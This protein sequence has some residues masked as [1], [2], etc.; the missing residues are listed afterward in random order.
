[1]ITIYTERCS[2]CGACVD[3]CPTGALYLVDGKATMDKAL[4]NT[5]KECLAA[6]SAE[7]IALTPQAEPVRVPA[8]HTD[9]QVCQE[10]LFRPGPEVIQ[11]RTQ[12]VS[13]RARVLPLAGAALAWAGREIL[14]WLADFLLDTLDRR[15]GA[16]QT[17]GAPAAPGRGPT[18]RSA[19]GT[20]KQHRHRRRKGRG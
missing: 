5:C 17:M 9:H 4:C 7:A 6:C 14:P 3:V 19:R 10:P 8:L 12:P 15:T 18:V 1:V 2:G 20:G 16:S 11:V 13:L